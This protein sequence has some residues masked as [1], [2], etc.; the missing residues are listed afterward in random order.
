MLSLGELLTVPAW[1]ARLAEVLRELPADMVEYKGLSR[2]GPPAAA[3][4]Q[5]RLAGERMEAA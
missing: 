1:G 3:W 4:L 2:T 5:R